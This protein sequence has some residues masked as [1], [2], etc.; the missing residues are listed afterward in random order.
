MRK[1]LAVLLIAGAVLACGVLLSPDDI[2]QASRKTEPPTEGT[3]GSETG[4]IKGKQRDS[5]VDSRMISGLREFVPDYPTDHAERVLS[6]YGYTAFDVA[7]QHGTV[8]LDGLRVLGIDGVQLM[9][10]Q[11]DTF[12]QLADRLGGERSIR[13][14]ALLR[15]HIGDLAS[16][17]G[18][19]SLIDRIEALDGR[20]ARLGDQYPQ[21]LPLLV[22]APDA[23][24]EV[25]SLYPE[26]AAECLM[27]VDLSRGSAGVRAM[28]DLIKAQVPRAG[29][30]FSAR[31][32]DGLILAHEYPDF[33][34]HDPPVKLEVFLQILRNNSD[35]ITSL[36]GREQR[37][38][39]LRAIATLAQ[40]DLRV[41]PAPESGW[42]PS[43]GLVRGMLLTLACEDSFTV[44]FVR[45]HGSEGIDV[46][47]STAAQWTGSGMGLPRTLYDAYDPAANGDA[48]RHA[49][50]SLRPRATRGTALDAL[51]TFAPWREL[52][53]EDWHPKA[54]E[55]VRLLAETDGR[56]PLWAAE[57]ERTRRSGPSGHV[58]A[59]DEWVVML[60]GAPF[61]LDQWAN[62]KKGTQP[63]EYL[64][65]YDTCRLLYVL[66]SGYQPTTGEVVFAA[67]DVA[68][69]AWDV[70]TFG[71]GTALRESAEASTKTIGK[72]AID[73]SEQSLRRS[74]REVSQSAVG[75]ASQ[76][77]LATA[78]RS[79]GVF[80]ALNQRVRHNADTAL[81]IMARGASAVSGAKRLGIVLRIGRYAAKE[82]A[83]NTAVGQGVEQAVL[84]AQRHRNDIVVQQVTEV[85]FAIGREN[86]G[87]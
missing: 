6:D 41:P 84:F 33:V 49:W 4:D 73:T 81:W 77:I 21:F 42:A 68:F 65:L 19:P 50:E 44:R 87:H 14:L 34:A 32:A 59:D 72:V 56:F 54:Q 28:C 85:L 66:G 26:I 76:G 62:A 53:G 80:R 25:L 22:V 31:G 15:D 13:M 10:T 8:G 46:L 30:W 47:A 69:T 40:A 57:N 82:T 11:P 67:V 51:Q 43:D 37:R 60:G 48:H 16:K 35:Y 83:I 29:E 7:R 9:R 75:A 71:A 70:A 23:V 2:D 86:G 38:E 12:R 20:A 5:P 17:G 74:G 79:P 27:I 1:L 45:E 18:L 78:T 61:R 39:V 36:Q 58:S 52:R 64:P 24:S 55:F 63:Q 3:A